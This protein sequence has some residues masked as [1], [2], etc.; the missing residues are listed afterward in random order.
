MFKFLRILTI[1]ARARVHST[2]AYGRVVVILASKNYVHLQI[3]ITPTIFHLI[4]MVMFIFGD[5][6]LNMFRA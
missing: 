1:E 2:M 5:T 3:L 4:V 6:L